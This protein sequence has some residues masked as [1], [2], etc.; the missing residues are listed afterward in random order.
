MTLSALQ[1][2]SLKT[3]AQVKP[4]QTMNFPTASGKDPDKGIKKGHQVPPQD[5]SQNG[6]GFRT[7]REQL[8]L[9]ELKVGSLEGNTNLCNFPSKQRFSVS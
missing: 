9:D 4:N 8:V 1:A 2:A 7:A 6:F 5:A 3:P